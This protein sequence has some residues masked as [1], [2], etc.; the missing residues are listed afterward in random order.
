MRYEYAEPL[1]GVAEVARRLGLKESTIRSWLLRRKNLAA[2]H[3][4]RAVRIP[5]QAVEEFIRRNTIPAREV[6]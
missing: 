1:L 6:R 3:C 5:A 4:G 2:V